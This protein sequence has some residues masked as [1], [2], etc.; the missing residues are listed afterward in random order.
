MSRVLGQ[1]GAPCSLF[2]LMLPQ[3]EHLHCCQGAQTSHLQHLKGT[4]VS[5][6]WAPLGNFAPQ[7]FLT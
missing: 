2:P 6:F 7:I 4:Y 3:L 5:P 1:L